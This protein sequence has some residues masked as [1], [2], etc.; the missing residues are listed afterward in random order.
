[1]PSTRRSPVTEAGPPRQARE[2]AAQAA[3]RQAEEAARIEAER[4]ARLI[5]EAEARAKVDEQRRRIDEAQRKAEE[6]KKKQEEQRQRDSERKPPQT[7]AFGQSSEAAPID[8]E[9]IPSVT[10][11]LGQP[12]TIPPIPNEA[13]LQKAKDQ[14]RPKSQDGASPPGRSGSISGRGSRGTHFP[15]PPFDGEKVPRRGG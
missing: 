10:S 1:M 13:D 8:V 14:R 5:A 2:A 4:Q 7:P 11:T 12:Q 6:E 3:I 9:P 15:S